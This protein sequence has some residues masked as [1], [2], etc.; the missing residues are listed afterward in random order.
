MSTPKKKH[1]EVVDEGS[2]GTNVN[3]PLIQKLLEKQLEHSL[4]IS[5]LKNQLSDTNNTVKKILT[6]IE[7]DHSTGQKG[8]VARVLDIEKTVD[9]H[10][11]FKNNLDGKMWGLALIGGIIASILSFV[12]TKILDK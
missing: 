8:I 6:Y 9:D 4:M 1:I 7:N 3:T 11:R 12:V 2:D 5:D 10:E